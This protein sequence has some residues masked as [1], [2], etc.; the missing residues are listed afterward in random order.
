MDKNGLLIVLLL[1][2]TTVLGRS[3]AL[4][5]RKLVST[6]DP[7]G[8]TDAIQDTPSSSSPNDKKSNPSPI[9]PTKPEDV[10]NTNPSNGE[11]KGSNDPNTKTTPENSTDK[12]VDKEK[13]QDAKKKVDSQTRLETFARQNCKGNSVCTDQ[14]K[15]MVACIQ[16]FDNGSNNLTLA[17]QNEQD[18]DLKVNVTSDTSLIDNLTA[19]HILGHATKQV[20]FILSGENSTKIILNGDCE[21]QIGQLKTNNDPPKSKDPDKTPK[22]KDENTPADIPRKP[23]EEKNP[24]KPKESTTPTNP[25]EI[26]EPPIPKTIDTPATSAKDT[27]SKDGNTPATSA[28][29]NPPP[30]PESVDVPISD[31]NFLDQ[32][33]FYSKKVTPMHGAYVAFLLVLVVGGSWALCSFRKRRN[34][35]GIP[36]QELEMGLPE[37]SNAGGVETVEGWDQDWDDDDWD[38][39]KAIRSPGGGVQPKTIS[40]NGLTSRKKDGWDA[41]W[42]D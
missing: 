25:K 22:P 15:T 38:E 28:K 8:S 29:D 21:L 26:K 13:S 16:E 12:K 18:I 36:Y 5:S 23:K 14:E 35:G 1:L 39:D 30:N 41:D 20:N 17:V 11:S 31:N 42:D 27:S 34:D 2:F 33:T 19:V 6:P 37:S 24:P 7:N 40:S 32:L 10:P 3:N 9:E 4:N